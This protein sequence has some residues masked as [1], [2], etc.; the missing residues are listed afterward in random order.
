MK[1]SFGIIAGLATLAFI[2]MP[3]TPAGAEPV[4]SEDGTVATVKTYDDFSTA[5]ANANVSTINLDGNIVVPEKVNIMH[6][7]TINGNNNTIDIKREA[8]WDSRFLQVYAQSD[9][10]EVTMRD[11][12]FTGGDLSVFVNGGTLNLEGTIN[13][14]G[15][16]GGIG[17]SQGDNVIAVPAVNFADGVKVTY[18]DEGHETPKGA[19]APA[20]YSEAG[21]FELKFDGINAAVCNVAE[22]QDFLY[23]DASKAPEVSADGAFT[24]LDVDD[25]RATPIADTEKPTDPETPDVTEPVDEGKDTEADVTAPNTGATIAN[26]AL[27]VTGAIVAILTAVYATRFA[28]ARK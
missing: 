9:P 17:I 21:S 20:I 8:K 27:V 3:G 1:K 10:I 12:T 19:P 22:S 24:A 5:V 18:A 28:S 16:Y 7:M 26:I 4:Y 23:F 15:N 25:Y 6:S 2:A 13:L 14:S 11:I